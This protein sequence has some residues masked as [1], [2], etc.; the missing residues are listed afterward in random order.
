MNR[1]TDHTGH[2]EQRRPRRRGL[3]GIG[4][5]TLALAV[6]AGVLPGRSTDAAGTNSIR[7][8][9][10]DIFVFGTD[11]DHMDAPPSITRVSSEGAVIWSRPLRGVDEPVSLG[12]HG[13]DRNLTEDAFYIWIST[14]GNNLVGGKGQVQ[15]YD[16]RGNHTWSALVDGEDQ[17]VTVSANPVKGGAWVATSIGITRLDKRGATVLSGLRFGLDTGSYWGVATDNRDGGAYVT[18][19]DNGIVLKIDAA[20]NEIWRVS[21]GEAYV[22]MYSPSDGGVYVGSGSY[23]SDTVKLSRLGEVEWVMHDFPSSYTYG[24]AV[25]P[26]DGSLYVTSGW[27]ARIGHV[28][29]DGTVLDNVYMNGGWGPVANQGLAASA[30]DDVLYTGDSVEQLGIGARQLDG[31]S[32]TEL[33]HLDPGWYAPDDDVYNP[34]YRPFTGMPRVR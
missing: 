23:A 5:V 31:D 27:D 13:A 14:Y 9:S 32:M 7:T 12:F 19:Y 29:A 33:W 34:L 6:L 24:R 26:V 30:F 18:N 16:S 28:A 8:K 20:G 10:S 3:L 22:P 11:Q 25:S 2:L 21:L 15:R 1:T 17:D 4:A